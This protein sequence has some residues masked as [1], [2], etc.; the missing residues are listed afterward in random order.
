MKFEANSMQ[1][2]LSRIH[3]D[4][5]EQ[6]PHEDKGIPFS[7]RNALKKQFEGTDKILENRKKVALFDMEHF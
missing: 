6:L 2:L 7:V 4:I 5:Y 3:Y 1:E